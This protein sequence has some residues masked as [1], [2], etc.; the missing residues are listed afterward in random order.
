MGEN[1][2]SQL[3]KLSWKEKVN[4]KGQ[5]RESSREVT[6]CGS[7][8]EQCVLGREPMEILAYWGK[9]NKQRK[10]EIPI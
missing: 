5:E 10:T 6:V 3:E 8:L 7:R 1:E 4:M 2:H 9:S